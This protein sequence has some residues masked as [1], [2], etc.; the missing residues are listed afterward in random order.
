MLGIPVR[1]TAGWT[2]ADLHSVDQTITFCQKMKMDKDKF[3]WV[4]LGGL[5]G[6]C[7]VLVVN[8]IMLSEMF[9]R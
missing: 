4:L 7:G 1:A 5:M 3:A 6:L 9:W 8:I 2:V